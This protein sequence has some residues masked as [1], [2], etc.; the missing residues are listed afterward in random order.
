MIRNPLV[1][2]LI[3]LLALAEIALAQPTRDAS[4]ADLG[5]QR[6]V[7]AR[8]RGAE[9]LAQIGAMEDLAPLAK[10]LRD[11]DPQVRLE[12]ERAMWQVWSRSGDAEADRLLSVGVQQMNAGA[13]EAAIDTFSRVIRLRPEFAEGW[14]KRATVYYLVGDYQKS[15]SDCDEVMKRN[16]FHF[17]ALSGYGMI[18]LQLGLL[19]KSLTYFE[20]A[21]QINPNLESVEETAE[22]LRRLLKQRRREAI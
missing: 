6:S 1:A 5:D 12:A 7:E 20:Q 3:G 21:L 16:R 10:A 14:N 2:A 17:G 9:G 15:L 22:M 19:D 13:P 18:Y 8:R 4:L 11:I